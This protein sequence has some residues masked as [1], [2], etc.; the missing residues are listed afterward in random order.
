MPDQL[1]RPLLFIAHEVGA[2]R[3][4]D[5]QG[6][7]EHSGP[8]GVLGIYN[9]RCSEYLRQTRWG[10]A[11]IADGSCADDETA[12]H[13]ATLRA[14]TLGVRQDRHNL[15]PGV[16]IGRGNK[17]HP[18]PVDSDVGVVVTYEGSAFFG[19]VRLSDVHL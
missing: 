9:I 13:P 16:R 8:P 2:K 4:V 10:V 6:R 1:L 19:D 11:Q 18:I 3:S 5:S 12:G 14:G 7:Q 17:E 15:G